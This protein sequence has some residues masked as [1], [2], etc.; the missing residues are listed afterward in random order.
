VSD[1]SRESRDDMYQKLTDEKI[2]E[3]LE[4]GIAEFAQNGRERANINDIAR[5]SGISVGALYKYYGSK[6]EFFLACLRHSLAVLK[7]VLSSAMEGEK[8]LLARAECLIRATQKCGRQYET[9]N[10]MYNEITAGRDRE[11]ARVLSEE[12]EG[13]TAELYTKFIADA[14]EDGT[15]RDDI[16]PGLFAFFFDNLLMTLQF[17]YSCDYYRERFKRYCGEDI[18]DRDDLVAD[19]LMKF[20]ES[21]FTFRRSDII[22]GKAADNE[23]CDSL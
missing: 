22:H 9:Y 18:L 4:T 1:D 5:K 12:I 15:V 6:D 7:D 21:A 8:K 20:M 16:D 3:L 2:N 10:M 11:F 23:I 19:E 13:M 17:S 14:E